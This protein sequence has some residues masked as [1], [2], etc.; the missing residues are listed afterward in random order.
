MGYLLSL[1]A[2]FGC[3]R[4][5]EIHFLKFDVLLS[6]TPQFLE[7]LYV[8]VIILLLPSANMLLVISIQLGTDVENKSQ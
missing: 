5:S 2:V 4:K 8:K 1:G 7:N 3:W 6:F